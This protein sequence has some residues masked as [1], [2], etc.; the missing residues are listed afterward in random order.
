MFLIQFSSSGNCHPHELYLLFID[1]IFSQ[2]DL[3]GVVAKLDKSDW[4]LPMLSSN[5][6]SVFIEFEILEK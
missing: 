6:G 5:S 4:D 1:P 2:E 3:A